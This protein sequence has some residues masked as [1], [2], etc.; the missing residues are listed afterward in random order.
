MKIHQLYADVTANIIKDLE[1]GTAPWVKPWKN[2]NTGG[3]L[4]KNAAT[5]RSYNGVNIPILWHGQISRGYPSEFFLG[6]RGHSCGHHNLAA[7]E[8]ASKP[9]IEKGDLVHRLPPR[10]HSNGATCG[11]PRS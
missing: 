6:Q 10:L 4:P 5:N 3:I 7:G 11:V 1:A 8:R 2:G 9:V